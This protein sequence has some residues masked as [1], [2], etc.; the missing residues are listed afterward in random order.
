MEDIKTEYKGYVI[1]YSQ[2]ID[3]VEEWEANLG[4]TCAYSNQSLD[5]VK[6]WIDR[7]EK[8]KFD[9]F[10]AYLRDYDRGYKLVTIT[11]IDENGVDAW[12]SDD[13]RKGKALLHWLV[14]NTPANVTIINQIQKINGDIKT[15]QEQETLLRGQL[16][17]L[18]TKGVK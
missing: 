14:A 9:R 7:K 11:S 13:G 12:Y 2:Y 15:L 1:R 3:G 6:K 4:S 5:A 17:T 10:Q 16:T 18:A 8:V